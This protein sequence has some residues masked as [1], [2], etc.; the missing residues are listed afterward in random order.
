MGPEPFSRRTAWDLRRNRIA[1]KVAELGEAG[2]PPLDLT[3]TNPTRVGLALD[4]ESILAELRSPA[5]LRY[6]PD[7]RGGLEA[8]EAVAALYGQRG[9]HVDPERIFLTASTSEAYS[10]I[11]RLLGDPGDRILVPAP[12]YPLFDHLAAV[13][14]VAAARYPLA[15]DDGF[16]VDPEALEGAATA[17]TRGILAVS[18]GNPTGRYLSRDDRRALVGACARR[19]LPLICDEVFGDYPLAP[20]ADPA[21]SLAGEERVLTFTLDGVSKML[22]LPQMKLGWMV[23]SGPGE[24]VEAASGRLEVLAD[25]FLSVSGPAQAALPGLLRRRRE[26]QEPVQER[27]RCNLDR[28]RRAFPGGHAAR[29]LPVQGG[30]S[31]VLRVPSVR[32][33]EEWVLELLDREGVLVH[34]GF[35]YDFPSEGRL[36][37]SLLPPPAAF[38]EGVERISR[39]VARV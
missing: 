29:P 10:W 34:P 28:L 8:R 11:F 9:V 30:W 14:D 22:A 27:L 1:E 17:R 7:P 15:E 23:L 2:R 36:V 20:P 13:S 3:E 32:T 12:S 16:R 33:D 35:F 31:A 4:G 39:R 18:P 38:R 21:G 24:L 26:M 6:D 25:T 19:E 5:A 37:L